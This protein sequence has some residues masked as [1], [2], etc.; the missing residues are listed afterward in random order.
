MGADV[1]LGYVQATCVEASEVEHQLAEGTRQE[2]SVRPPSCRDTARSDNELNIERDFNVI[3]IS[4]PL[5]KA[6]L[7]RALRKLP[8]VCDLTNP[9]AYKLFELNV[10]K[11]LERALS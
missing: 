11:R 5:G 7:E 6:L 9:A 4:S 8:K 1:C 10:G 2:T 3:N